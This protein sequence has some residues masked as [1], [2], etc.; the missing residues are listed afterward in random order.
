MYFLGYETFSFGIQNEIPHDVIIFYWSAFLYLPNCVFVP[1]MWSAF[2]TWRHH[3]LG[4][5]TETLKVLKGRNATWSG[6]WPSDFIL[7]IEKK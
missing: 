4:E 3:P 7:R 2:R 6:Q 5:V 1:H